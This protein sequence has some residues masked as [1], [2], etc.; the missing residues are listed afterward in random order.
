MDLQGA[1]DHSQAVGVAVCVVGME[2]GAAALMLSCVVGTQAVP[3]GTVPPKRR[4]ALLPSVCC[5]GAGRGKAWWSPAGGLPLERGEG[6]RRKCWRLCS[7]Y[8]EQALGC[9]LG[10]VLKVPSQLR[11]VSLASGRQG[12]R[13]HSPV[14]V[15]PG[16]PDPENQLGQ[17]PTGWPAPWPLGLSSGWGCAGQGEGPWGNAGGAWPGDRGGCW[18]PSLFSGAVGHRPR[19]LGCG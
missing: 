2:A 14:T 9:P 16:G 7:G 15:H 1:D 12:L 18:G 5:M 17:M 6:Q 19:L 11:Q 8:C 10:K 4:P 13:C 3:S